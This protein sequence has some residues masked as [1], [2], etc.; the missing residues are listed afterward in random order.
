MI[1][2]SGKEA[3]C[4]G[5]RVRTP[6]EEAASKIQQE[7]DKRVWFQ[8][9]PLYL[10]FNSFLTGIMKPAAVFFPEELDTLTSY[11][12]EIDL[13]D[14]RTRMMEICNEI[15]KIVEQE[16][17]NANWSRD[18]RDILEKLDL[19]VDYSVQYN[20][21]NGEEGLRIGREARAIC[22]SLLILVR[23]Y[24]NEKEEL[25]ADYEN[26]LEALREEDREL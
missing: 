20:A 2:K 4:S 17:S 23:S 10:E 25:K 26:R 19:L 15:D 13:S 3:D 1:V 24:E 22:D 21:Q 11:F 9:I 16:G 7:A 8:Y 18:S 14:P 5:Y 12:R 6:K